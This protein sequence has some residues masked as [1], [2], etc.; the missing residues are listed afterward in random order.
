[1]SSPHKKAVADQTDSM[2]LNLPVDGIP[3]NPDIASST[4][5]PA[6]AAL[7]ENKSKKAL[8]FSEDLVI[9]D[10]QLR[11]NPGTETSGD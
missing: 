10:R 1:M 6:L 7:P 2:E 9:V 4:E 3:K 5:F 11:R 8:R